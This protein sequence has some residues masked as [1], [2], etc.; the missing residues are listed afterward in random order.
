MDRKNFPSS[1]MP[2]PVTRREFVSHLGSTLAAAGLISTVSKLWAAQ[3]QPASPKTTLVG[4]N[5]YGWTQYAQREK[6]KFDVQEVISALR[7]TGY[8]YLES[9]MSVEQPDE[10]TRFAEQLRAKG[11]QPVSLYVGARLH[12][13]QKAREVVARIITAAKV[14]QESGFRVIS[15]NADPIGREKTDEELKTQAAALTEL[16]EGLNA[17]G[18]KLGEEAI[19][20][21]AP[22]RG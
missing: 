11:L 17:L 15:C 16:G 8:D 9:F 21:T 10:N 20:C 7:D 13:S 22:V 3:E 14:C 1:A 4:S 12:E 19:T 6:K 5:V 18:L 2:A